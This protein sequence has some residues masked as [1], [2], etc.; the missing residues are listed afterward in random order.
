MAKLQHTACLSGAT[1]PANVGQACLYSSQFTHQRK[2]SLLVWQ[3]FWRFLVE[4]A[5]D[6]LWLISWHNGLQLWVVFEHLCPALCFR[7]PRVD[8]V[9][10]EEYRL[11]LRKVLAL[12]LCQFSWSC[13][14]LKNF[15]VLR[16]ELLVAERNFAPDDCLEPGIR[17]FCRTLD[18]C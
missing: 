5:I 18:E 9:I 2:D 7:K 3:S 1:G 12:N 14:V 16:F 8:W 11:P 4:K 17:Q 15:P 13:N 10:S 6:N